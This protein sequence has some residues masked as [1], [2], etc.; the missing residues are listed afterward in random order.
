MTTT[1]GMTYRQWAQAELGHLHHGYDV[2][3][4]TKDE[5]LDRILYLT[6]V[7]FPIRKALYGFD[8]P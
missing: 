8:A 2:G 1:R 6:G 3:V 4:I 7:Q 5:W